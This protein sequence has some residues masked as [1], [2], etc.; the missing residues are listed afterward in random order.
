MLDA[1]RPQG[2]STDVPISRDQNNDD[3]KPETNLAITT[4]DNLSC[5]TTGSSNYIRRSVSAPTTSSNRQ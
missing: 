1:P 2:E 3:N 5:K 4:D